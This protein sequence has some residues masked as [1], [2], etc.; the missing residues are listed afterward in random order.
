ME[1]Y[2]PSLFI[3]LLAG[4]VIVGFLP[5]LSSVVITVLC[6][7]LLVWSVMNHYTVFSKEYRNMNWINTAT[8]AGPYLLIILVIMLSLGYIILVSTS[9]K[10]ISIPSPSMTIPPPETA[11]NYVT[12]GIGNS[13][14]NSGLSKVSSSNQYSLNASVLSKKI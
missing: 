12:R 3:L 14:I 2:I 7:V 8:V 9:G 5:Q 6:T 11:T 4:V 10:D 1:F 13:L